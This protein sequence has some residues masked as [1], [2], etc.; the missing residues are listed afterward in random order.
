MNY[1]ELFRQQ[2]LSECVTMCHD[3][4][5]GIAA[6]MCGATRLQ[7]SARCLRPTAAQK[8]WKFGPV[9]SFEATLINEMVRVLP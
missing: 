6:Q 9:R 5:L 1:H 8:S 3:V 7:L 2:H 4:S